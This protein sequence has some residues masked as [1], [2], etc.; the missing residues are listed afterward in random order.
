MIAE[1]RF[2]ALRQGSLVHHA[3]SLDE[4]VSGLRRQ[5][6]DERRVVIE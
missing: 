2:V 4:L 1:N 5:G 3:E 6:V